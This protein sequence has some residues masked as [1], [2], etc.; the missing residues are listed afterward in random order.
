M[1]FMS[2]RAAGILFTFIM[3]LVGVFSGFEIGIQKGEYDGKMKLQKRET[4]FFMKK[5]MYQ[6]DLTIDSLSL[7]DNGRYVGKIP[8]D[9]KHLDS[10]ILSDYQKR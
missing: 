2:E 6:M 10:L 9:H 5:H 1:I 8:R 7:Y 4:E 3:C